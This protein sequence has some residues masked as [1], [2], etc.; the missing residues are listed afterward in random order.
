MLPSH[1]GERIPVECLSSLTLILLPYDFSI[2]WGSIAHFLII[3]IDIYLK[4]NG[5]WVWCGIIKQAWQ[6][7]RPYIIFFRLVIKVQNPIR[8]SLSCLHSFEISFLFMIIHVYAVPLITGSTNIFFP[9]S[10]ENRFQMGVLMGLAN[11]GPPQVGPG[12]NI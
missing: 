10:I 12:L 2:I 1:V 7:F 11:L 8:E 5:N 6:G 3:Y 9:H 4:L